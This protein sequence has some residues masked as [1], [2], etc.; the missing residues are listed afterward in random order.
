MAE[1]TRIE[2]KDLQKLIANEIKMAWKE[3]F[4]HGREQ[5]AVTVEGWGSDYPASHLVAA[6]RKLEPPS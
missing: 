3:G 5:C 1:M 6:I 2:T 4:E